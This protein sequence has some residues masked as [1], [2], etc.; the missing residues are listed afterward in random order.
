MRDYRFKT[1]LDFVL[2]LSTG[3][4][5]LQAVFD[6]VFDALVVAGFEVQELEFLQAAPVAAVEFG[7]VAQAERGGDA[8]AVAGGDDHENIVGH[9][10]AELAKEI[11]R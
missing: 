10:G 11:E 3:V 2:A 4:E 9:G 1:T 6:A 7:V 5:A 8:A